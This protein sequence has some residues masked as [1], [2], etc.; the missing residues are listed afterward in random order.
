VKHLADGTRDLG[1]LRPYFREDVARTIMSIAIARPDWFE[2]LDA[3][4]RAFGVD[5]PVLVN[6]SMR[7]ITHVPD[8]SVT[9]TED[10]GW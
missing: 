6:G 10:K 9:V 4:G 8:K 3:V 7:I 2:C 1:E 5:L